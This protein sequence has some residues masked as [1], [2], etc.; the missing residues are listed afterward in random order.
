[1]TGFSVTP[2]GSFPPAEDE[3]FPRFIQFQYEGVNL[4]GPDA[5]T[6]NFV[7]LIVATRGDSGVDENTVTVMLSTP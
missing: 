1:M 5:D 6:V 3:G 4:G 7:G 2:V